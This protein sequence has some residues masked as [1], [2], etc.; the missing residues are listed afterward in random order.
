MT[1]TT[2]TA[3]QRLNAGLTAILA[4]H[5]AESMAV[6]DHG[7]LCTMGGGGYSPALAATLT[8]LD[9]R[10]DEDSEQWLVQP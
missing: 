7:L 9:W 4:E 1:D 10:Y 2:T 6:A 5:P 8:A 3:A